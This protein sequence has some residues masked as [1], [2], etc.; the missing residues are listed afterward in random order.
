MRLVLAAVALGLVVGGVWFYRVEKATVRRQA[1]QEFSAIAHTKVAQIITWRDGRLGDGAQITDG[2]FLAEAVARYLAVPDGVKAEQLRERFRSFAKYNHYVDILL[3][4]PDGRVRLSLTGGAEAPADYSEALADALRGR[5][6]VLTDLHTDARYPRPHISVVAPIFDGDGPTAPPLGAVIMVCDAAQYLYPLIQAWPAPS[7]TAETLLARRDGNSV[8]FLNDLRHRSGA[9]LTLRIPLSRTDVPAVMGVLGYRGLVEGLDYSG[10]ETVAVVE[11][12][13][14]S[15]WVVVAKEDAAEV[16]AGWNLRATEFFSILLVALGSVATV[17]FIAWQRDQKAHFRALYRAEATLRASVERHS[18]TLKAVGDGIVATDVHGCVEL[19]NPVAEALTGWSQSEAFGR[20]LPE[21][22]QIVREETL[23]PAE[24]PVGRV[25][26]DGLVVGL[27]NHTLLVAKNGARKPIADSAAPIRN[28][29]GDITGVVLVFRDQ[30]EER[31]MQRLIKLRLDLLDYASTHGLEEILTRALDEL[32]LVLDS[33]IGF[34]HLL[35]SDEK[36]LVLS[37]WSTR[38][39]SEFCEAEDKGV[40]SNID[41]CGVWADCVRE[42]RPVIHNDYASLPNRKGTP[43]GHPAIVRELLVPVIRES[44]VVAILVTGN[45]PM[46]YTEQDVETAAYVADVAW[47]IVE[48]KRVEEKRREADVRFRAIYDRVNIGIAELSLDHRFRR[49]NPTYCRWLGYSEE[50]LIGRHLRDVTDPTDVEN[51]L[52]LQGRLAS[53]TIDNYGMEKRFVCKDGREVDGLLSATLVRDAAG[54]PAYTLGAVV[55]VT[56]RKRAEE[57]RHSLQGQLMQASKMESVGRL[58]GG[59][60]H[61]FN[62]V[63]LVVLGRTEMALDRTDP[64]TRLHGDLLEIQKAALR[65]AD[66]TRQLL[67]FARKQVVAPKVLD[68]DGTVEGTLKMLRRLIGEDIDLLWRPRAGQW[69]VKIDPAQLDQVMANLCVNARDAI[70]GVGRVTIETDTV[71]LDEAYC[72]THAGFVSGEFVLLAVS[73]DGCGMDGDTQ[74]R[75]F[76]PFFTTKAMGHGTGLGLATVYGIV[77]QNDGFVNVYSEP[78]GGSTFKI[79]F[80]RCE[81]E[82]AERGKAPA[83]NVR[84]SRGETILLVEDET[85]ILNVAAAMLRRFG[86]TVLTAN[87]AREAIRMCETHGGKIHLLVTDV[88]MGEMNGRDLSARLSMIRPDLRRLFMSGYTATI[89]AERGVLD[90]GVDFI[91]K[92]FSMQDLAAKVGEALDRP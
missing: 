39:L 16:F 15:T 90:E 77:K 69:R 12:V 62:N 28:E 37:Q 17:G 4:S 60:A 49:A 9:A 84:V 34:Y 6:P 70:D 14:D 73:D 31:R 3:A 88:V 51:N 35:E 42:K 13:P 32:G 47:H 40:R 45:K 76:E 53:G 56:E 18:V 7:R 5:K 79:Y 57:E 21:V 2:P 41:Q 52:H 83:A 26:R 55:D 23:A 10:V 85:P 72:A 44:R 68:L 54:Q 89:I 91:Q 29:H 1:E 66:L 75:I 8:L 22:F 71:T 74:K 11:P 78:G 80:P 50:E 64:A 20:P 38:T 48:A 25:L 65:S 30:T 87:T 46:P 27:A 24:D 82:A 67:A 63:L 92:P 81:S 43:E 58:A 61:D 36:T 19:L 86:Y 33:P 59:I